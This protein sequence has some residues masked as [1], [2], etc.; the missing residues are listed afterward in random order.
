M[1]TYNKQH[2]LSER[3]RNALWL[4]AGL[5]IAVLLLLAANL[6]AD[7][8][9]RVRL[10][11]FRGDVSDM[12]KISE[13]IITD[14]LR[15][16]D[17]SLLVLR[18]S[19][20]SEPHRFVNNIRLLRSGPLADRDVLVVLND[21]E[22]Y[23]TYTDA[24]NAKPGL[25]MGKAAYF[26]YFADGGKDS[27]HIAAPLFGRV[28]QRYTI[29]LVRPVYNK[30]GSFSGVVALSV[31]QDSIANFGP[32]L[33]LSGN[34]TVTVVYNDGAIVSRSRDFSKVQGTKIS[35]ELLAPL[36]K[37]ENGVFSGRSSIDAVERVVAYRHIP[38][39]PLIV[40]VE[41]SFE[42]VLREVSQ[43]RSILMWIAV[44]TSLIILA[45]IIVYLKGRKTS[46]LLIESL[47]K[48]KEQEYEVLTQTS[49]DGF[50]MT[51]G[52]GQI[53]DANDTICK[54]LGYTREE[55]LSLN[56]MDIE[57]DETPEQIAAYTRKLVE[58]GF[59]RFES[60]HR[61][62][63]GA[64]IDVEVSVQYLAGVEERFF[65]FVRNITDLK[66]AEN[67]LI[68]SQERLHLSTRAANIGIWDWDVANNK[69]TWDDSMYTL[70]GIHKEVFSGAYDAWSRTIH[71][72]D[73]QHTEAEI[74]AALR[75]EQEYSLEFRIIRP[76]GTVRFIQAHSK[77]F[78]DEHGKPLRMIGTNFDITERK[79][80]EEELKESEYFFRESQRSASI[81]SYKTDFISGHW[82][83]SEVM[84]NI[85]GIDRDYNR[86][87]QAWLNI[88]H[89]DDLG[90]ME[91]YLREE[92]LSK[93]KTFDKEYRIIRRNDGECRWV[94]GLG[95][96]KFDSNGNVL[97]M[98]GT[99]QDITER[100]QLEQQLQHTQ[101]LESLGVLAGGIAHD[102]NNLLAVIIGHC[103]LA[104]LRP[105]AAVEHIPQI[106]KAADRA[107]ELCR[108]M[109]AYAGKSQL[110][111]TQVDLGSLVNEMVR[112]LK[113]TIKKN[114]DIKLALSADIPSIRGDASQINQIVMNLI[115]NASEAIGEAQGE[116]CVSLAKAEIS[117]ERAEKDYIGNLI[118]S[119]RYLRLE[120]T[121][122]GCGM[123]DETKKRIFEPFYTTKF[124][125]RG[126]GMSAVLGIITAHKG[127]LQLS[128]HPGHGATFNVFLPI[129]DDGSD[130]DESL[131][132]VSPASWQGSGTILLVEDEEQ[133]RQVA[134][135]LLKELGFKLIEASNG[136]EALEQY[137]NNAAE[138]TLVVT[139]MDMPVMDGY[140]LFRE[141]NNI[142]PEL[143]VI[144]SSGFGDADITS[145]I[146]EGEIA[147][148]LNKPYRFDQL[149]DVLRG[150][151]EEH[152]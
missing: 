109:L 121:D 5:L 64:I 111:M 10:D 108:Q 91:R 151:T 4:L 85:F 45:L 117:A 63:D 58:A 38:S 7:R 54:I 14:R 150:V 139:D 69:L 103:S 2:G 15:D 50:W 87:V 57:V 130:G 145:R 95:A 129:Q 96:V 33:Q 136:K 128:S 137:R 24:P 52:L 68:E 116:V 44:L 138:I 124:T 114:V 62:K 3:W 84:D 28:T 80:A 83:S 23:V 61:R 67:S 78:F 79:H 30:Q 146:A 81:G 132:Q 120:V 113:S 105:D 122:N 89:P 55:L 98:I 39:T 13:S 49:P 6:E 140:Q 125:G 100:K 9:E 18:D 144:I 123:D 75:G 74:Q 71:P 65:V 133:I 118:P 77:T 51:D 86:N 102:F 29:P 43:Q 8:Q 59:A 149:R 94:H 34:T 60:R 147:G 143:P 36:L 22:G 41:A 42:N 1:T 112:M 88:V 21:R 131:R 32:R 26:R 25:F 12:V 53:L 93:R 104:T 127:A 126:L 110:F 72:E 73:L 107:A 56:I 11:D 115:I 141:L 37:G 17:N 99:I 134:R 46:L 106:E 135:I 82:E 31:K 142:N 47:R 20:A 48:S 119:G 92:V 90:M 19:Y 70:Y 27:L 152:C 66:I 76:D 97:S 35:P 101:K 16:Y 148:F 40:Y